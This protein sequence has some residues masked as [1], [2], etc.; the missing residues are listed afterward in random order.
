MG[1]G[2]V[3]E[4]LFYVGHCSGSNR[5]RRSVKRILFKYFVA[6]SY[7]LCVLFAWIHSFEMP[8]GYLSLCLCVLSIANPESKICSNAV[9]YKSWQ[10]ND[11][12]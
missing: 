9:N 10:P 6:V 8:K 1:W 11:S 5:T 2:G 12:G 7:C 4:L 3:K